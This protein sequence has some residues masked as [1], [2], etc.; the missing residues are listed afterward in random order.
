[1]FMI[2]FFMF[3]SKILGDKKAAPVASDSS[4]KMGTK[5]AVSVEEPAT[6]VSTVSRFFL[7]V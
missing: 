2:D 6:E 7:T 4:D 3:I 1:M 5:K